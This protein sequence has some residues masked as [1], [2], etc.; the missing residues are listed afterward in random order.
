MVALEI[1]ARHD[2]KDARTK[3]PRL[4]G[5][6]MSLCLSDGAYLYGRPDWWQEKG[7]SVVSGEHLWFSEWGLRLGKPQET[8]RVQPEEKGFYRRQF[9]HGWSVYAPLELAFA[10]EI[11]F[12]EDVESVGTGKRG[13]VHTLLPGHGDLFLKK[14]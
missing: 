2:L 4:A 6:A 1:W 3:P 13:R 8:R 5:L 10:K 9:E 12:T 11:E 14:N 7:K